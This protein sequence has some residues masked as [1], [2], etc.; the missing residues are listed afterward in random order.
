MTIFD[1]L[2]FF[3]LINV[4]VLNR[5]FLNCSNTHSAQ[6]TLFIAPLDERVKRKYGEG[7]E[8]RLHPAVH[9]FGGLIELYNKN[10]HCKFENR[11][12]VEEAVFCTF[13]VGSRTLG[14][15]S[16]E[17]MDQNATDPPLE[18]IRLYNSSWTK[19]TLRDFIANPSRYKKTS[20][21]FKR[22]SP[23]KK[24]SAVEQSATSTDLEAKSLDEEFS[25]LSVSE[26]ITIGDLL[27]FLRASY[28]ETIDHLDELHWN[29]LEIFDE[30]MLEWE[31]RDDEYHGGFGIEDYSNYAE[32]EGHGTELNW[33]DHFKR[34]RRDEWLLGVRE[35]YKRETPPKSARLILDARFKRPFKLE[36][37]PRGEFYVNLS[38]V[39][40]IQEP[41]IEV[42]TRWGEYTGYTNERWGEYTN[43]RANDYSLV[44]PWSCE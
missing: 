39:R 14:R 37:N 8:V 35:K 40:F 13:T 2:D 27:Q 17:F 32:D 16:K 23:L 18:Q 44:L 10:K 29:P 22:K 21:R 30:E 28:V 33:E 12:G 7:K 20:K 11:E 1:Y 31:E 19:K 4:K 15:L 3:D 26:V 41:L 6:E 43:E 38:E 25:N 36:V 34:I 24:S 9:S 5:F 42:E